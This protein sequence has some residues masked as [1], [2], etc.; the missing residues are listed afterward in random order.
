M[1][2]KWEHRI[3]TVNRNRLAPGQE[4]GTV[5]EQG[6]DAVMSVLAPSP[7]GSPGANSPG[8]NPEA[9]GAW[10]PHLAVSL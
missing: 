6:C 2:L 9:T 3:L 1:S 5:L 8:A 4:A 10:G 7:A